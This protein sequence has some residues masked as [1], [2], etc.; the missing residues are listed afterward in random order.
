MEDLIS[1]WSYFLFLETTICA[2]YIR[3]WALLDRFDSI[4]RHDLSRGYIY[5]YWMVRK[6]RKRQIVE[7]EE[8]QAGDCSFR[9]C[10]V[11]QVGRFGRTESLWDYS[12]TR[13][14]ED[15]PCLAD[16]TSS[17]R[18]LGTTRRIYRIPVSHQG[19]RTVQNVCMVRSLFSLR[20]DPN[21]KYS[22]GLRT[23]PRATYEIRQPCNVP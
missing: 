12:M 7:M 16:P 1:G 6:R 4:D 3:R 8:G 18:S 5:I 19:L 10:S 21:W 14:L 11:G 17:C 23:C 9:S 22:S 20:L 13:V 2:I 15:G